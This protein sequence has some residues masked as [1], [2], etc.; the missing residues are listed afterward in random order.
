MHTAEVQKA[1]AQHMNELLN[2]GIRLSEEHFTYYVRKE[3]TDDV[4]AI[5]PG[6]YLH[7]SGPFGLNDCVITTTHPTAFDTNLTVLGFDAVT[8]VPVHGE[9]I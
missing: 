5:C 4:R 2:L 6:K 7:L 3:G 9:K 1:H 8:V